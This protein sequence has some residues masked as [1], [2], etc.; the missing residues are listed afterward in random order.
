MLENAR[1]NQL[2]AGTQRYWI[3]WQGDCDQVRPHRAHRDAT[4]EFTQISGDSFVVDDFD[5]TAAKLDL[6]TP[7]GL[8]AR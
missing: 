1:V 3:Y 8:S 2:A 7:Y 4:Y 5:N 6:G